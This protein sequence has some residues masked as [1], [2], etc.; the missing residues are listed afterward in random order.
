MERKT[1]QIRT[2]SFGDFQIGQNHPLVLIAGPCVIE[3]ETETLQLARE[4][5]VCCRKF[6][7]PL[8]FKASYDKANRTSLHSYRGPGLEKGLSILGRVRR[9]LGVPILSDVH[10]RQEVQAAAAVLDVIQIPAFLCRQTDLLLTAARTGKAINVKK[11]QFLSPW[12]VYPII[13]KIV[14]TGNENLL[15]TERGTCFGYNQ[16][17]TDFRALAIMKKFGYPVVYDA[18]HSVQQPGGLGKSSGG[19]SEFVFPLARAAVAVG[20]DGLFLEVHQEP[21]KALSD[22]PNMLQLKLLPELL[23]QVLKIRKA[24]G[25]EETKNT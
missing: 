17:V 3:G 24:L 4:I 19:Q 20:C 23:G 25:H 8:I 21:N 6:G 12:E 9:E 10:C 22:G 11:G 14:S 2:I 13:E 16:L 15:L 5:L 1:E 7:V 18:T